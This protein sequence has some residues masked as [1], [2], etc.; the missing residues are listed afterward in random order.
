MGRYNRLQVDRGELN[1]KLTKNENMILSFFSVPG[2]SEAKLKDFYSEQSNQLALLVTVDAKGNTVTTSAVTVSGKDW[3]Y[4]LAQPATEAALQAKPWTWVV[5]QDLS[6]RPTEAGNVADF[7]KDGETF[8]DRIGKASPGAGILLYETWPRPAGDFYSKAPGKVLNNP[9]QMMQE[10]HKAYG[11]LHDDLTA[12]NPKREA[13]VALVGTA[14]ALSESKYPAINL[15]A[16]DAHH[17]TADGYYLAALVIYETA[18]HD[19]AKGA[20]TEFYDGALKIP[21]DDA[22]KLQEIADEVAGSATK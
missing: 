7:M 4:H 9:E 5:L 11:D 8:S 20:P 13:R 17:A 21:A 6:T 22:A 3:A 2:V 12:K 19:S 16:S 15:N 18:Y 10:L 1:V 14:F